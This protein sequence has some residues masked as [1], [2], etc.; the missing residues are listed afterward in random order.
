MSD[1]HIAQQHSPASGAQPAFGARLMTPLLLGSVLNPV[2]ST[3]IATALVAIGRGFQV[4]AADTAWLVAA[5]YLASAVAQPTMGR[6]ADMFGARRVF[7]AGLLVVLAAG[8]VGT[9]APAF[10]W[11]IASRVLLGIGTSAAY[12]CAMAILRLRATRLDRPVP[13]NVLARLSL[14]SLA[15]AAVGPVLGGALAATLGWRAIFAVNVPVAA[16]SLVLALRWLPRDAEAPRDTGRQE[17]PSPD[18]SVDGLGILLFAATL[19]TAMLFLMDLQHPRWLLL[20]PAAALGGALVW[21]QLRRPA[22][23]LDLR[24]LAGNPPLVRTY[25]RHGLSYLVIYLVMYGFAQWME[26]AH[27]LS[28]FHSGLVMLPM[29][30][31]AAV[32]SL[33][34]ARTKGIRGPLTL[35]A[36]LLAVGSAVLL[37]AEH[38]TP[39]AVLLSAAVLF[40]LPQGLAGTS[41]QA[42]VAAQAARDGVGAAAGLQRTAQ[43][44]GAITAS[45]LI[46]L[47]Y[48]ARATDAG[49]HQVALAAGVLSILVLVLTLTDRALH[50]RSAS[51]GE[52]TAAPAGERTRQP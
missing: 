20:V 34:G 38:H 2:N 15:S 10:G 48:G 52:R 5:L 37:F 14:A 40:G 44:I 19:A 36:A 41:N 4:G 47:C 17:S 18:R 43:Y 30:L 24:M 35:G 51:R 25:L 22:P 39:V 3:M 12:P 21:W 16:V 45:S 7:H 11:L 1:A 31:A 8:V 46:A 6:L 26:E 29:S 32:C 33:L 28:A 9:L 23:F 27:G 50:R 42:A 49:L 13:R